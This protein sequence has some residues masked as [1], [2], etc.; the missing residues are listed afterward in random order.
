MYTL[1]KVFLFLRMK[2]LEWIKF[3]EN[4]DHSPSSNYNSNNLNKK[5]S[6]TSKHIY[7]YIYPITSYN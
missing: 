1:P 5:G 4:G 6:S 3:G 2:Y 7:I